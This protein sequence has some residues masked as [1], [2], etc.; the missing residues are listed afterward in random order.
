MGRGAGTRRR[1]ATERD[2]CMSSRHGYRKRGGPVGRRWRQHGP[3]P[4]VCVGDNAPHCAVEANLR[5]PVNP[6][7]LAAGWTR[8]RSRPLRGHRRAYPAVSHPSVGTPEYGGIYRPRPSEPGTDPVARVRG[9]P[10]C[11][12]TPTS[13][14][15][16]GAAWGTGDPVYLPL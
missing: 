3:S 10:R 2:I 4:P 16:V 11:R 6:E 15:S 7:R 12:Q 14:A 1:G 9:D 13:P 5:G 8:R